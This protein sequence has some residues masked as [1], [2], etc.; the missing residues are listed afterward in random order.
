MFDYD[1]YTQKRRGTLSYTGM[2]FK[3]YVCGTIFVFLQGIQSEKV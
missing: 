1:A 3:K 2:V